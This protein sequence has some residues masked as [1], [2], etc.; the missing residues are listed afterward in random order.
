MAVGKW[1]TCFWF[2]TFPSAS[3]PEL[4]KCGNLA[5]SWRDFQGPVETGGSLLLAFH[6]FHRPVISTALFR[7][8]F[9][10]FFEHQ[11][12]LHLDA[13]YARGRHASRICG[14]D[15]RLFGH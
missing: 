13:L 11:F 7:L 3:S 6:G 15:R 4:W 9:F 10:A 8:L 2:F 12:S 1:E 5:C 14:V